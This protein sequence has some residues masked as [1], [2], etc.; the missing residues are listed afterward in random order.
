MLASIRGAAITSRCGRDAG[1]ATLSNW[2][3]FGR[4]IVGAGVGP[5]RCWVV[6]GGGEGS[7]GV[8]EAVLCLVDVLCEGARRT[9]NGG[10]GGR[11]VKFPV[12]CCVRLRKR[13]KTLG[14]CARLR[15]YRCVTRV[16]MVGW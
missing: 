9:R 13:S 16:K 7:E 5:W 6:G 14:M 10:N 2:F 11:C 1:D 8:G 4:R 3:T 15:V 12:L